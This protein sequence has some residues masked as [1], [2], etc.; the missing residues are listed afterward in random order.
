[1][2]PRDSV[3]T[4]FCGTKRKISNQKYNIGV[5]REGE[6]CPLCHDLGFDFLLGEYGLG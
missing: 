6:E 2:V 1:M 4:F 5:V 3:E